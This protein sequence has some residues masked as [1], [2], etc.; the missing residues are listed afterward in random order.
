MHYGLK[1]KPHKTT[2][3]T[4]GIVAVAF[5]MNQQMNLI[6]YHDIEIKNKFYLFN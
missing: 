2:P 5:S 1:I 6:H 3:S 4:L